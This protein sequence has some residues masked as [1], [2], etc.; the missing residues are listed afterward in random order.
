MLPYVFDDDEAICRLG[1][2]FDVIIYF[3]VVVNIAYFCV[4]WFRDVT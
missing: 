3:F 1:F 2:F 4:R